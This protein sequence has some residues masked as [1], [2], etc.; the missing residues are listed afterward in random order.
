MREK[1]KYLPELKMGNDGAGAW[2]NFCESTSSVPPL[3]FLDRGHCS[4]TEA[5]LAWGGGGHQFT[6]LGL[7]A[8][9]LDL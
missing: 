3:G 8:G 6:T 2:Y 9:A 1:P 5:H 4:K 7:G